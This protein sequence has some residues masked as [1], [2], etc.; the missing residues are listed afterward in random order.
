MAFLLAWKWIYRFFVSEDIIQAGAAKNY[1]A[2]FCSRFSI[3]SAPS[4]SCRS[5]FTD[6]AMQD[7]R[8]LGLILAIRLGGQPEYRTGALLATLTAHR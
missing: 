4:R 6:G 1:L 8:A 5:A 7:R 3:R 2:S